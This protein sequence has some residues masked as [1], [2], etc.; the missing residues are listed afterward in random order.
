M[1][2]STSKLVTILNHHSF[3]VYLFAAA[4]LLTYSY[5]TG[6]LGSLILESKSP[7][8]SLELSTHDIPRSPL[9]YYIIPYKLTHVYLPFG[10]NGTLLL[11]V[12]LNPLFL[13]FFL[14]NRVLLIAPNTS[15]YLMDTLCIHLS[16]AHERLLRV[17]THLSTS[18]LLHYY[19]YLLFLSLSV[20]IVQYVFILMHYSYCMLCLF[21]SP[22]C[23]IHFLFI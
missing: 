10:P 22:K 8:T 6:A 11:A 16:G 9:F 2:P 14:Y 15:A 4:H 1:F 7:I 23:S 20:N 3:S 19:C 18:D 12:T 21:F 5:R 13:S 17:P